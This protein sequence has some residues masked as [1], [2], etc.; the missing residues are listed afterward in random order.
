MTFKGTLDRHYTNTKTKETMW[1]KDAEED[2]GRYWARRSGSRCGSL[3]CWTGPRR[4]GTGWLGGTARHAA[5]RTPCASGGR[6]GNGER[7]RRHPAL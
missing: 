5:V 2:E 6:T 4:R 7:L 1:L 3:G